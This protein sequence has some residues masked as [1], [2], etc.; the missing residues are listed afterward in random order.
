MVSAYIWPEGSK[1]PSR[2]DLP[3][4]VGFRGFWLTSAIRQLFDLQVRTDVFH[5][6]GYHTTWSSCID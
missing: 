5:P 4:H 6:S 2:I 1:M 3:V